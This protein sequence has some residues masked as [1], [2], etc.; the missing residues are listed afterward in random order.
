MLKGSKRGFNGLN[1][2]S[3]RYLL[4]VHETGTILF[5]LLY[6]VRFLFALN[7]KPINLRLCH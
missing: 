4:Y 5:W 2:S 3:L 7:P 1:F 6:S